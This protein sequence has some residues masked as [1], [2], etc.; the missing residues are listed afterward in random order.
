[1][2]TSPDA[3][4]VNVAIP[5]EAFD[6]DIA[7]FA[8]S[9]GVGVYGVSGSKVQSLV[10]PTRVS[11]S[12]GVNASIPSEIAHGTV[13]GFSLTIINTGGKSL[14]G[15]EVSYFPTE[16]IAPD[17]PNGYQVKLGD[18]LPGSSRNATFVARVPK[19]AKPGYYPVMFKVSAYRF[20]PYRNLVHFRVV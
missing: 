17:T 1:M 8:S 3:D 4:E 11:M 18:I 20:S 12:V 14:L 19:E 5:F 13:F 7:Y 10:Q 15:A 16:A 6:E 9:L 2:R